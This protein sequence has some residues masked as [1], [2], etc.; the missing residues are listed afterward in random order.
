MAE[1]RYRTVAALISDTHKL[2]SSCVDKSY[3]F[4]LVMKTIRVRFPFPALVPGVVLVNV[5]L[6]ALISAMSNFIPVAKFYGYFSGSIPGRQPYVGRLPNG[7]V[8][9]VGRH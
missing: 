2:H 1:H 5:T 6:I 9:T 3:F 8:T 4:S 7:G